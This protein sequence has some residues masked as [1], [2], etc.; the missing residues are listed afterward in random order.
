MNRP[1]RADAADLPVPEPAAL[2]HCARLTGV[3]RSEIDAAD[4]WIPFRRFMELALHE[5]GLGYY[6]AG[7]VKFGPHGDFTT[8]PEI[9][10]LFPACLA[11]QCAELLERSG[12]A[13]LE[14]GAGSGVMALGILESLRAAGRLPDEY[15]ILEPSADL[16]RRQQQLLEARLPGVR[17]RVRW[18]DTLPAAPLRGVILAN[19]VLDAMPVH[20]IRLHGSHV[21]E[22]GVTWHDRGFS[23]GTRPAAPAL[24]ARARELLRDLGVSTVTYDTEVNMGLPDWIASIAAVL[25]R[26]AVLLL[27]YGYPRREY[28]HQ[29]RLAGTLIC[30]YRHRVHAD[31]FL[32]PGLQDISASVDFTAVAEAAAAAGLVLGGF[33]TQAH[34]LIG[35]GLHELPQLGGA[36]DDLR[37]LE[38]V[39]Q[40]KLLTLPGEM[41]ER[42]KAM[43]LLRDTAG[44]MIGF[45]GADHRRRL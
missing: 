42:F 12:G 19:E 8:A 4:G 14:L 25:E 28:Y 18:L 1:R 37:R 5:P 10:P 9:S 32:Y 43:A 36:P 31:P 35:C 33:T 7:S 45:G 22:L 13:I 30:H 40:A 3:I 21:E 2:E 39:R 6:S 29:D 41:G 38:F 24:A 26:G 16:R 27:D 23:W 17:A 11:R 44:S 15:L 34:F 20:R